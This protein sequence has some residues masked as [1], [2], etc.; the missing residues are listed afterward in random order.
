VSDVIEREAWIHEKSL[1]SACVLT[2]W[3]KRAVKQSC[4]QRGFNRWLTDE[5]MNQ[6]RPIQSSLYLV[7]ES[8]LDD[9]YSCSC[10]R[11]KASAGRIVEET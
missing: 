7:N 6:K 5:W 1:R 2:I 11:W 10:L 9:D 3:P 4:R 8:L